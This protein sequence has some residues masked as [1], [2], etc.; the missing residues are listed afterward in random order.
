MQLTDTDSAK[1]LMGDQLRA[2]RRERTRFTEYQLSKLRDTF[3]H[4]QHPKW[5]QVLE[6]ASEVQLPESV[7]KSWFKNQL[8]KRKKRQ[9]ASKQQPVTPEGSPHQDNNGGQ[10]PSAAALH[11]QLP[12]S[13]RVHPGPKKSPQSAK[14]ATPGPSVPPACLPVEEL[15]VSLTEL[16]SYSIEELATLYR[17]SGNEDR[18]CMDKY[19]R[20]PAQQD[21]PSPCP[22]PDSVMPQ[23]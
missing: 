21:S 8:T 1:A 23:P 15:E 10:V 14:S 16:L 13:R 19:L 9:Q 18:S 5:D 22:R 3:R 12:S 20:K 4:T 6:V 17:V 2:A 7:V 11:P